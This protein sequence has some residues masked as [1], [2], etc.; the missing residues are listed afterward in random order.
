M[1]WKDVPPGFDFSQPL[2]NPRWE[3]FSQLRALHGKS[4]SEAYSAMGGKGNPPKQAKKLTQR[5]Q[6]QGRTKWLQE[7]AV[8]KTLAEDRLTRENVLAEAFENIDSA[9]SGGIVT[10]QGKTVYLTRPATPDELEANPEKLDYLVYDDQGEPIPVRKRDH[11]AIQR[12]VEMLGRELGM[13]PNHAKV[14]HSKAKPFE[15]L[16]TEQILLE[17]QA[18]FEIE[19]GMKIELSDLAKLMRNAVGDVEDAELVVPELPAQT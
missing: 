1:A 10:F 6:I 2:Q 7:H 19:M 12:T 17:A 14:E 18:Q 9:K 8:E 13:F 4:G 3:R 16:T 15:G 5:W 11:S